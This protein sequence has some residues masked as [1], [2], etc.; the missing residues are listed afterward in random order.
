MDKTKVPEPT[1]MPVDSAQWVKQLN[2]CNFINA[3]CQYRDIMACGDVKSILIIGPGQGL[4]TAVFKWKGFE[5]TTFDID[6]TFVPDVI[7]SVHDMSMFANGQFD[8]VIASHV[9]E[10]LAEPYLDLAIAELAR[11]A[12]VALVYLPVA[13]RHSQIRCIPGFK[14]LNLSFIFDLFNYFHKPDGFTPR[15]CAGQHF[16]EVGF[17][18]FRKADVIARMSRFFEVKSVYRNCDWIPSFNLVMKSR[19]FLS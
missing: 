4:D 10:H 18:G 3:G 1:V 12:R 11:V 6:A 2:L 7:G 16:W 8:A 14:D 15:Y 9:L 17:R 19:M 5:V 13:G